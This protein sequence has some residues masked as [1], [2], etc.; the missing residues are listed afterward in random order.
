MISEPRELLVW[1]KRV[2]CLHIVVR[3]ALGYMVPLRVQLKSRG[4]EFH[5]SAMALWFNKD[6]AP[7]SQRY[8]KI[9]LWLDN[10]NSEYY[11]PI[12]TF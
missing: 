12:L 6:K 9:Y 5:P 4:F 1:R 10:C 3:R 11:A 2:Y 7:F 8:L